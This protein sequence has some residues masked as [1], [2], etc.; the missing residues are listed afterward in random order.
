MQL[1]FTFPPS[2]PLALNAVVADKEIVP[3]TFKIIVPPAPP[4]PAPSFP[5]HVIVVF[6]P[7][8]PSASMVPAPD[9]LP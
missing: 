3:L 5:E 4:P 7:L 8:F 2:P 1:K 9:K 6:K